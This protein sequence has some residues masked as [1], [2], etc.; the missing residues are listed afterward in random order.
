MINKNNK[1]LLT[2]LQM[3]EFVSKGFL[4]FENLIDNKTNLDFLKEIGQTPTKTKSKKTKNL[5]TENIE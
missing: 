1:Y 4:I 3:A 2:D 5:K